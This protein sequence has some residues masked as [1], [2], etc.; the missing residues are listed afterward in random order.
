LS[1]SF[2]KLSK[3]RDKTIAAMLDRLEKKFTS[4]AGATTLEKREI[5]LSGRPAGVL[6]M[7][8]KPGNAA[9]V[10]RSLIVLENDGVLIN[11]VMTG[12]AQIE[13]E[14]E[15]SWDSFILNFNLP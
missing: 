5:T 8:V 9:S 1:I 4:I 13:K 14:L 6:G 7:K 12:P 10:V 3:E 2:G 15:I 11:C